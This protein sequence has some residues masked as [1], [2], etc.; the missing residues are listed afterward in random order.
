MAS[1][2][3]KIKLKFKKVGAGKP[4]SEKLPGSP[5]VI[6]VIRPEELKIGESYYSW[7]CGANSCGKMLAHFRVS[8]GFKPE[9]I[10]HNSVKIECPYCNAAL[11]YSVNER[12]VRN[13][14]G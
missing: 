2:R 11:H 9:P 3:D 1:L 7:M 8:P 10:P 5:Y 14:L 4:P 12:R 6:E 13:Y